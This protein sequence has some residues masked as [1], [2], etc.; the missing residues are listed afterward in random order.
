MEFFIMLGLWLC[1]GLVLSLIYK[2]GDK[3][4]EE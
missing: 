2:L 4:D 3:D 1:L